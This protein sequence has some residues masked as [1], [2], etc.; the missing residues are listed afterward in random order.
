[1]SETAARP[2]DDPATVEMAVDRPGTPR[3][4]VDFAGRTDAGKVRD[5]NQDQFLV[6]KLAKAMRVLAT[7]LPADDSI[8]LGDDRG[9]LLVVADGM[10]GHAA[11]ERASALAVNTIEGFV[12]NSLQWFFRLHVGEETFL[13][14]ELREALKMADRTLGDWADVEPGLA[15]MGTTLTLAFSVD[16]R[17]FLAHAGDSRAYLF[18]DGQLE[19]LTRDHTFVQSMVD[20]GLM[21][22]QQARQDKRRNLVT[23]A[24][25]GPSPGV[26][27]ELH[28]LTLL[29]GDT[30]LL[31]TDGLTG[32]VEDARIAA[33]LAE[34]AEPE[35]ACDALIDL[36]LARGAP[37]NVTAV[38]ARY[39]VA[40]AAAAEQ[41]QRV[42]R[43]A[44]LAGL[45]VKLAEAFDAGDTRR[46]AAARQQLRKFGWEVS[47]PAGP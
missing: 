17:L 4:W 42:A 13:L 39:S 19:Q 45:F 27:A 21:T 9:A 46:V 22:A 35:D 38:V 32:P 37:D 43:R 5:H 40:S 12:L 15:G 36:A 3:V 10:G 26:H 18:R 44:L 30:L 31:C 14:R 24:L 28:R 1:M 11:G 7:S 20:A 2:G 33:V 47:P 23:N 6:A 29:D 8:R 34:G 25:G 41:A 16:D